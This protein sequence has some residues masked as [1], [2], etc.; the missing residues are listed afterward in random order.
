MFCV[1]YIFNTFYSSIVFMNP[2]AIVDD[3]PASLA[4]MRLILNRAGFNN[5]KSYGDPRKAMSAFK[6]AP[7][8]VLIVDYMMPELDGVQLI[9]ELQ[10]DQSLKHLPVALVTGYA[11]VD[12]VRLPALR[13]GALLI[14]PKPI[15]SEEFVVAVRNLER[16]AMVPIGHSGSF[17]DTGFQ[18]LVVPRDGGTTSP[19]CTSGLH[20]KT[21]QRLLARVAAM[22]DE[23]TGDHVRRM[24][25]YAAAI[26]HRLGFSVAQQDQMLAAAPLHD[27]GKIGIPHSILHKPTA[28]TASE[29]K[30]MERHTV[31]GF[32]LL[33]DETFPLLALG[34]EIALTHHERWDG[35]GYPSQL[36]GEDISLAGRIVAVAD[37]FD[38]LTTTRPYKSSWTVDR[39]VQAIVA[40]AGHQF[41]PDVVQAFEEGLDDCLRIKRFFDGAT[42]DGAKTMLN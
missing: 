5:V 24:A 8:S 35:T 12:D 30:V 32:D 26:S 33:H 10:Q 38:A 19:I 20:D 14:I 2:I 40:G 11:N 1:V 15:R 39:A 21:V 3:N 42:P 18:P 27:F 9:D 17:A 6:L 29:R 22:H 31:I 34:A 37:V 25:H 13:A 28:L 23:A 41:D 4:Q 7:P 16:M 36:A